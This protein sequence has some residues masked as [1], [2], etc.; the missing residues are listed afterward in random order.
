MLIEKITECEHRLMKKLNFKQKKF[1]N[2]T[3]D[4]A[5]KLKHQGGY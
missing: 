2:L 5:V 4:Q 1:F 3:E